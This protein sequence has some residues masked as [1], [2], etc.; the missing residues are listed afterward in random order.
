MRLRSFIGIHLSRQ[1]A[2]MFIA[3]TKACFD[4]ARKLVDLL[5]TIWQ[6]GSI[7]TSD[8]HHSIDSVLGEDGILLFS[9][10][11]EIV[12]AMFGR[13]AALTTS[14]RWAFEKLQHHQTVTK[15]NHE[16]MIGRGVACI[17]MTYTLVQ[18]TQAALEAVGDIDLSEL[19]VVIPD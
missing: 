3:I 11:S 7:V 4:D 9:S 5:L 17:E 8:K 2:R 1:T 18:K 14:V 10:T 12:R 15:D 6:H 13:I 16:I 19:K